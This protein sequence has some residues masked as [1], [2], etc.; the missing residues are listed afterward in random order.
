MKKKILILFALLGIIMCSCLKEY[1]PSEIPEKYSQF[2]PY[3]YG[4]KVL[5]K[6]STDTVVVEFF[7]FNQIKKECH[8]DGWYVNINGDVQW[9][10]NVNK[11]KKQYYRAYLNFKYWDNKDVGYFDIDYSGGDNVKLQ[12]TIILLRGNN[13][14][15][16]YA[17]F[18]KNKGLVEIKYPAD[19][20]YC[21]NE[22]MTLIE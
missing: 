11:E 20:Y 2:F 4:Q 22:I 16:G 12:D 17:I 3:Y 18:V 5:F 21:P 19:H 15:N 9:I 6:R 10:N 1:P 14:N 13:K 7:L 8:G